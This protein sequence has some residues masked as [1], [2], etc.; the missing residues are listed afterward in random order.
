M[1]DA[2]LLTLARLASLIA[3][4]K[5]TG[6]EKLCCVR[7]IQSRV[8]TAW[9]PMEQD[10]PADSRARLVAGHELLGQHLHL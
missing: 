7:C 10:P 3:K 9:M 2:R 6:Y 4:W 5:R 8:S 1:G